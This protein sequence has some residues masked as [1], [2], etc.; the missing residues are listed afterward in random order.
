MCLNSEISLIIFIFNVIIC[1]FLYRRNNVNDR[2]VACIFGYVG[3]MQLLEYLMWID[4]ECS[5]LNQQATHVGF[6]LVISQPLVALATA[7]YMT[8]GR[9]EYWVYAVTLS[10]LL[11]SAPIIYKGKEPNQ[12]SKPCPGSDIG[13]SWLWAP[14]TSLVW[15]IFC[16]AISAPF[17][18]MKRN[19]HIYFI[20]VI[21]LFLLA[22]IIGSHRC[23]GPTAVPSGSLWCLFAFVGPFMGVFI[24][25]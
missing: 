23:N 17:L 25:R 4:Q 15:I 16:L 11:Y 19:G 2:W 6:W 5:G 21:A 20:G 9:L 10:Y 18:A 8:G 22:G 7:Y 14:S 13:L 24:N 12:C 3:S 1:S